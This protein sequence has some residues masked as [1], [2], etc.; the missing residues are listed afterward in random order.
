MIIL[1]LKINLSS[2]STLCLHG[3]PFCKERMAIFW[4][5]ENK[6]LISRDAV[7]EKA[8]FTFAK[9][10][11]DLFPR[12]MIILLPI[13]ASLILVH[14]W[15]AFNTIVRILAT[16]SLGPCRQ[17]EYTI[18]GVSF[19]PGPHC[20]PISYAGSTFFLP[21]HYPSP[22]G[23]QV[24]WFGGSSP[25]KYGLFST[26]PHA[27]SQLSSQ[28]LAL[29]MDLVASFSRQP[30]AVSPPPVQIIYSS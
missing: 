14:P 9:V 28:P 25:S 4:P 11:H 13:P 1:L 8:T 5:Q 21:Q 27:P 24:C 2:E 17:G 15:V 26:S 30:H 16:F 19:V 20:W 29:S 23:P 10:F 18:S 3:I 6:F 7:F 12:I 22:S